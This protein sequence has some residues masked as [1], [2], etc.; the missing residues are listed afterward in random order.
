MLS[1]VPFIAFV[2]VTDLS[3]ATSFYGDTLGLATTSHGPFALS[4]DL[5]GTMLRLTAVERLTPQPFTI[6]GW[7]VENLDAAVRQLTER[8]VAFASFD[9]V[10]QDELG[11][12]TAPNG[13]RVAWFFDPDGNVL[14]LTAFAT[15]TRD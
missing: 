9:G 10:D 15:E 14:S 3:V 12:W 2:P 7:S 6:A 5:G 11:I 1:S 8:G 4:V 13:D